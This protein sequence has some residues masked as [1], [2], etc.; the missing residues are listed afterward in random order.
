MNSKKRTLILSCILFSLILMGF[1]A[2]YQV[3][4]NTEASATVFLD[5]SNTISE[6][7]TTA[8]VTD[9]ATN[10]NPEPIKSLYY[11]YVSSKWS[12]IKC[13]Q[14]PDYLATQY[15]ALN[16]VG[17]TLNKYPS[18]SMGTTKA[19][20]LLKTGPGASYSNVVQL[21]LGKTIE[22]IGEIT[23]PTGEKWLM[24]KYAYA[25]YYLA[26]SDIEII[27]PPP[28]PAT[29]TTASKSTTQTTPSTVTAPPPAATAATENA[30]KIVNLAYSKLGSAYVYGATGPNSFD[31]SGFVY[32]VVNNSG[33]PGL[34]VPRT[35]SALYTKFSS[36]NIGTDIA[37]AHPGDIILFSRDGSI[38]HSAIY[39]KD[40]KMIHASEP[41][42]GVILTTVAYST[43]NKSVFAIIRLPGC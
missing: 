38:V 5:S 2:I 12:R 32:W 37:N 13:N 8:A 3:F 43:S 40:S 33:I 17:S 35:S 22:I 19:V 6:P 42:T 28:T 20:T 18:S 41:S 10:L 7:I 26:A 39:Y 29:P 36:Y 31:C 16:T 25:I 23:N 9:T 21:P 14:Q 30:Q 15:I 11:I 24:Y 27:A 4:Y 1:G 34:S